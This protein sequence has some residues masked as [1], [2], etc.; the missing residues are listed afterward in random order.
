MLFGLIVQMTGLL[1]YPQSLAR[2]ARE[3]DAA[4][5]EHSMQG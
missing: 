4:C 2:L 3:A 5:I 1:G